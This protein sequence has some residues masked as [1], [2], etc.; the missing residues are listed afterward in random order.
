MV[1]MIIVIM[2]C[3]NGEVVWCQVGVN[4][5]LA[6]SGLTCIVTFKPVFILVNEAQVSYL[7]SMSLLLFIY[8]NFYISYILH[9]SLCGSTTK[10]LCHSG[11]VVKHWTCDH[12]V[13][14][15][16]SHLEQLCS[17][18]GQVT[19][20]YVPLSVSPSSITWY[21]SGN[22]DILWLGR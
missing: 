22:G 5:Y 19:R 3:I 4:I 18:L 10:P 2:M 7:S 8:H 20:T 1:M 16:D 9:R 12:Q 15:L 11:T 13:V 17:N 6:G 21:Q 14:G